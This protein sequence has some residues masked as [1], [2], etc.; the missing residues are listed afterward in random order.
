MRGKRT[1]S[2]LNSGDALSTGYS[3]PF[4]CGVFRTGC[5]P[6]TVTSAGDFGRA[7]D[8][9]VKVTCLFSPAFK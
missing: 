5:P 7:S 1:A 4:T 3:V 9:M 6:P 8:A 2:S